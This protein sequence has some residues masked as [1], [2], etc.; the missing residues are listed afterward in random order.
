MQP[1]IRQGYGCDCNQEPAQIVAHKRQNKRKI[2]QR[3]LSSNQADKEPVKPHDAP[4]LP[5]IQGESPFSQAYS[6]PM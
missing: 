3:L 1:L 4:S 2:I 6:V 5:N